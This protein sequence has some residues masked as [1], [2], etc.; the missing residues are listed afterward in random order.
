MSDLIAKFISTGG[1]LCGV[2]VMF[3]GYK[4][5]LPLLIAVGLV[6]AIATSRTL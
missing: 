1:L 4:L 6:M 2:G 5:E 3:I